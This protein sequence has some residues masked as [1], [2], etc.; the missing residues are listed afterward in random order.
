MSDVCRDGHRWRRR[1]E[2]GHETVYCTGCNRP[3]YVEQ[4]LRAYV[5]MNP[6]DSIV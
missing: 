3:M 4:M 6:K 1:S 2:R 5:A